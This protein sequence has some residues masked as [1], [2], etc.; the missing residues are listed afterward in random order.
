MRARLDA[1]IAH[2]ANPDFFDPKRTG[3]GKKK[4]ELLDNE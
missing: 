3:A 1:L 2:P 4:T